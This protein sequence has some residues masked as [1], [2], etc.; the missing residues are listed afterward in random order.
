MTDLI[1]APK[2]IQHLIA[3]TTNRSIPFMRRIRVEFTNGYALSI[4]NG[5]YS[6]GADKGLFE[7]APINQQDEL[8]GSLFDEEDQGDDVLGHCDIDKLNH[9]IRKL[10]H[11]PEH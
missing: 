3:R 11:L 9:Y 6:Y 4:I 1:T 7:I 5:E 10:A 8:D 2:D